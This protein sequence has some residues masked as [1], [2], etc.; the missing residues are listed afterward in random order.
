MHF[1][2]QF[3]MKIQLALVFSLLATTAGFAAVGDRVDSLATLSGRTYRDVTIAQVGPDGVFFRHSNGAGKVLFTDLAGD[4]RQR[5]G[6]DSKKAESYEKERAARR[7]RERLACI[8]RDG[9]IAKARASAS[10]AAV[11]Q[12]N[13]IR[14]QYIVAAAQ[15]APNYGYGMTYPMIWG[16][17]GGYGWYTDRIP[18][19]GYGGRAF[20][21]VKRPLNPSCVGN[22]PFSTRQITRGAPPYSGTYSG[23]VRFS[24]GVPALNS[25]FSATPAGRQPPV[26]RGTAT[27]PVNISLPARSGR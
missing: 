5:M 3:D 14:A 22:Q 18:S 10:L 24:N 15:Q 23:P 21:T 13:A 19:P 25:S 20:Y 17:G 7:E 8:K 11:A 9:E 27:G 1:K 16:F 6:Y 4:V 2:P 26:V 12:A